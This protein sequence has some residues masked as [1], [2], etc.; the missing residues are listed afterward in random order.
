MARPEIKI[1]YKLR[2]AKTA[3]RNLLLGLAFEL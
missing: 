2:L 1:T 3:R